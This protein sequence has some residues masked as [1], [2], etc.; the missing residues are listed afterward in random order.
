[1]RNRSS[2]S[3]LAIPL[4]VLLVVVVTMMPTEAVAVESAWTVTSAP[5]DWFTDAVWSNGIPNQPGDVAT[6]TGQFGNPVIAGLSGL[7]TIGEL[8]FTGSA[9]LTLG[10][11]GSLLFDNLGAEPARLAAFGNQA[12][13]VFDVATPIA[14]ASGQELLL[15]VN[16]NSTLRTSG[17]FVPGNGL[18]R[19]VGGGVVELTGASTGW[20]GDF[21]LEAG[22]VRV[23]HTKSLLNSSAVTAR[24]GT[25]VTVVA[26]RATSEDTRDPYI[27]P[28]LILDGATLQSNLG[29]RRD[30]TSLGTNIELLSDSI[31]RSPTGTFG[32]MLEGTISGPGGVSYLQHLNP[33][34]RTRTSRFRINGA[35]S[36]SGETVI[37]PN[38]QV[39]FLQPNA[40]GDT[41][42]GTRV[43][44]GELWLNGGG[45]AEDIV[46]ENGR[47]D[48]GDSTTPYGNTVFLNSGNLTG[49]GDDAPGTLST[50]VEYIN[51]AVLGSESNS[52]NLVL[53]SGIEGVGSLAIQNSVKIQG[54]VTVRGNLYIRNRAGAQISGPLRLAG[55]T[56]IDRVSLRLT[57]DVDAP[58]S[59]FRIAPTFETADA[60]LLVAANNTVG[61]IVLDPRRARREGT[62]NRTQL[63]VA[64]DA[65]LTIADELRFMGGVIRGA[66]VGQSVLTKQDRTVGTLEDIAG[67]GFERVNVEAGQL[68][69]RGD[70]GASAPDI[71]LQPHDTSRVLLADTGV[72]RGDIYL[73]NAQGYAN[74]AA[75]TLSGDTTLAGDLFLGDEGA[76]LSG[77]NFGDRTSV[78]SN[79]AIRGGDLT[80]MGRAPIFIRGGDHAYSG[81][82]NVMAESLVL[83][84]G[85]RLNSTSA[86]VGSGRATAGGGRS[87]LVLDNTGTIANNDRIPD[88]T[89]VY[90]NGMRFTLMGR[91]GQTVTESLGQVYAG[92]GIGD[93]VVENPNPANG[94]TELRIQ[95]LIR[96]PGAAIQFSAADPSARI[97]FAEA[98]ALDDGLIGGWA[99]F[100]TNEFVNE[101][102]TYGPNG[103]VPYSDLYTY[104]SDLATAASADNVSLLSQNVV[105]ASDKNINAL[106]GRNAEIDLNGKTLTIESGGLLGGRPQRLVIR[107]EGA[108]TAG[109][110]DGAELIL[111]GNLQIDANITDNAQGSVGLTFSDAFKN[112]SAFLTLSGENSYSGPT[113]VNAGILIA[114]SSTALPTGT[115]VILNGANLRAN[116][117]TGS[118]LE[119]GRIELR[120]N[121][122]VSSL[123][124]FSPQLQPESILVESGTFQAVE[125]VGDAPITKIGPGRASFER[126][127]A[128]HSGPID[129]EA[130]DFFINALGAAPIEDAYAITIYEGGSLRTSS[131]FVIADRKI[132]LDGGV[133]DIELRGGVSA[134]IEVLSGGGALRN[135]RGTT[136]IT[137]AI[138]GAG[139]LTVEGG[140]GRGLISFNADLNAFDGDLLFTGGSIRMEGNNANYN[141]SIRIAAS[142]LASFGPSPFGS[143]Q[144]TVLAEGQL[145]VSDPLTANVRLAG[146]VLRFGN[147]MPSPVLQ[148]SLTIADH[149]Y[150]FITPAFDGRQNSPQ[151]LS[152]VVLENGSNLTITQAPDAYSDY[153]ERLFR[154]NLR[155]DSNLKVDG[156]TTL[157]SFDSTVDIFGTIAPVSPNAVLN[158]VGNDTFNVRASV[159]LAN[160]DSLTIIEDDG[161]GRVVLDRT[162]RTLSGQG[163]LVSDVLLKN[164]A[165]VSPGTEGAGELVVQGDLTFGRLA[166]YD[167]EI[168][169]GSGTA[170]VDWD[171]LDIQG[172]LL[173][174]SS[175][176]LLKLSNLPGFQLTQDAP[177]LIASA[178]NI[179]GFDA[180]SAIINVSGIQADF[181]LLTADQ[182]VLYTDGGNLLLRVVPEPT[183]WL[184][185]LIT[186][187]TV[188]GL[189]RFRSP[190]TCSFQLENMND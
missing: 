157:T 86:I 119:L 70:A 8:R 66:I 41:N 161:P 171:L 54:G 164:L 10:G 31:I 11:A 118:P 153:R 121:A 126:S 81:V 79:A 15:D 14:I 38:V 183:S 166:V 62:F 51:G 83:I 50:R 78:D 177:W 159:Q 120:D 189:C 122:E 109:L 82:T 100:D 46:V 85:G 175:F 37:G 48:L 113:T 18:I 167:W 84:D 130:G 25:F 2:S 49:G 88:D 136:V 60:R 28:R 144:V 134:P 21:V 93:L 91:D 63:T 29:E 59:K 140:F 187:F 135:E 124:E 53:A 112:N 169:N 90:L 80:L 58:E 71:Y 107:G 125:F 57:G 61:T 110:E 105:L 64:D 77:G 155:I 35:T 69:I 158:L 87:G 139:D 94:S 173:F 76:S 72:Y 103:V 47:L 27:I 5:G 132:R 4:L 43:L 95:T 151:I 146:G 9:D 89:P 45:G 142:N 20:S 115:D 24:P 160:G 133:I 73:N 32:I 138:T 68:V 7:A 34:L 65:V 185:A 36:Y 22:E 179:Q 165:S 106:K 154:E 108:L 176:F 174:D 156:S 52:A 26:Q 3:F 127:L 6:L 98:P 74:E 141:R 19:K 152:D 40:L 111:A 131:D 102:A 114:T 129:I 16:A 33:P 178:E 56:F 1:M 128:T 182:F 170:G 162:D 117:Q 97:T 190:P 143:S 30:V 55:E 188:T 99:L 17:G 13:R 104:K 145:S 39:V 123:L 96:Q 101:F 184:L 163:R 67:S 172:D 150:L 137:S 186:A 12:G 44:R 116:F 180:T 147:Q 75:L 42:A 148:G 23:E 92:R 149:S 168:A 181:P